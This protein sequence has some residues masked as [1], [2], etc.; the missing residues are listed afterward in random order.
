MH[1]ER[2]TNTTGIS[3]KMQYEGKEFGNL[4]VINYVNAREVICRC[5]C[6]KH[7]IVT[8]RK[9]KLDEGS[10]TSC[11]CLSEHS[12]NKNTYEKIKTDEYTVIE[13][14]NALNIRCK[15]SCGNSFLTTKTHIDNNEVHSCGCRQHLVNY[16]LKY[17]LNSKGYLTIGK[18]IGY[19]IYECRCVCGSNCYRSRQQLDSI[20]NPSCGCKQG[21]SN[22]RTQSNIK[23][24]EK[25]YNYILNN[26]GKTLQEIANELALSYSTIQKAVH[27]LNLESN[28]TYNDSTSHAEKEL[29]ALIEELGISAVYN[30]RAIISPLELDIYIPEKKIAIEFNGNYWHSDKYIDKNY[31]RDK[32][33]NCAQ[34]GIKLI[35]VFEYE[36][37]DDR[38]RS[39]LENIIKGNIIDNKHTIYARDTTIK[40]VD[41]EIYKNFC[42][43]YHLQG[44]TNAS[45][46]L[47]CYYNTELI[48]IMSFGNPRF[49]NEYEYEL[50]RLCWKDNI[51]VVGGS[52][53]LFTYFKNS[54]KPSSIVT[55]CNISKFG[56]KVYTSLGFKLCGITEPNY[57]WTKNKFNETLTRYQTQKHKLVEQ[58]LGTEEQ[59]EDEIMKSLGYI[60]VYDSGNIILEWMP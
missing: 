8:T 56:G 46:T 51:K 25:I 55:Y 29:R 5:N 40:E 33:F 59:T 13:Y 35:H 45:V 21:R 42:N 20:E 15:C 7:T 2:K 12:L 10:V 26:N 31:H 48:G 6:D 11:G 34:K 49:N 43:K 36:W 50:I 27:T 24:L 16:D 44:Y 38:K 37:T 1:K 39:I 52:E 23:L 28:V 9:Y 22:G 60:K 30:S 3:N 17:K 57:V 58:G 19:G 53:K 47:G 32:T 14:I 18:H 4:T 41:N 54:Y